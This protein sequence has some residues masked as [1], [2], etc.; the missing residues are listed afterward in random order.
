MLLWTIWAFTEWSQL[1]DGQSSQVIAYVQAIYGTFR[2]V[3]NNVHRIGNK[4]NNVHEG[5][6][7]K[8]KHTKKRSCSLFSTT[9]ECMFDLPRSCPLCVCVP[10]L[11]Q[12]NKIQVWK[13][14]INTT[15][16]TLKP[17]QRIHQNM[18]SWF[19]IPSSDCL[20]QY[21]QLFLIWRFKPAL[22]FKNCWIRHYGKFQTCS[23]RITHTRIVPSQKSL[24][25]FN[26]QDFICSWEHRL[27]LK[28][29][30]IGT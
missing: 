2:T 12:F 9:S 19:Q 3:C 27:F 13:D 6:N 15:C 26:S 24:I 17:Q 25:V 28:S 22:N 29:G 18:Y 16:A 21:T 8:K 5:E 14:F 23:L 4:E 1:T 30:S 11:S 20:W 10:Q 7:E